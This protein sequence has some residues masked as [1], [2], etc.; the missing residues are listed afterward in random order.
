M[1]WSRGL[2]SRHKTFQSGQSS[3]PA[4]WCPSSPSQAPHWLHGW[5]CRQEM[6]N[7]AHN[8]KHLSPPACP[9]ERNCSVSWGIVP[10]PPL[11][12]A[13]RAGWCGSWREWGRK[14]RY[15]VLCSLHWSD[16]CLPAELKLTV[17]F[18][19]DSAGPAR[20]GREEAAGSLSHHH[21]PSLV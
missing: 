6:T 15:W 2:Q 1:G 21:Q 11:S 9:V 17:L 16:S 4:G 14:C 20:T 10:L 3:S 5:S 13:D 8:Y 19:S 12:P 7:R 18:S